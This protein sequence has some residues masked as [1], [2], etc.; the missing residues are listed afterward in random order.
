MARWCSCDTY[1]FDDTSKSCLWCGK[2][3]QPEIKP[4]VGSRN[5]PLDSHGI[6]EPGDG[7]FIRLMDGTLVSRKSPPPAAVTRSNIADQAGQPQPENQGRKKRHKR[8]DK[9]VSSA[10]A[11]TPNAGAQ[12][13]IRASFFSY[14]YVVEIELIAGNE[15]FKIADA[16]RPRA[17]ELFR[18]SDFLYQH[19]GSFGHRAISEIQKS[20]FGA[21]RQRSRPFH[22]AKFTGGC[23]DVDG[24]IGRFRF[25]VERKG[26]AYSWSGK[27]WS[28]ADPVDPYPL[29]SPRS[30]DESAEHFHGPKLFPDWKSCIGDAVGHLVQA[31]EQPSWRFTLVDEHVKTLSE[32]APQSE[33]FRW[34]PLCKGAQRDLGGIF[35]R[36][37][38]Q[39]RQAGWDEVGEGATTG[40]WFERRLRAIRRK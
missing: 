10:R 36:Y 33:T 1:N 39:L 17:S 30:E 11:P 7:Q 19:Y 34:D 35:N 31:V 25:N 29:R 12:A 5:A 28:Q 32:G 18:D 2:T 23:F 38:A 6:R 21:Q 24:Q 8:E 40:G 22:S 20:G 37:L 15:R 16:A 27:A 26:D 14:G 9:R 3:L 4:I 13:A